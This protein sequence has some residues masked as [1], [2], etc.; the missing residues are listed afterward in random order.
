MQAL[1]DQQQRAEA[2]RRRESRGRAG[3]GRGE[4]RRGEGSGEASSAPWLL[5]GRRLRPEGLGPLSWDIGKVLGL[6]GES[7]L[8]S[9]MSM[10]NPFS[11]GTSEECAGERGDEEFREKMEMWWGRGDNQCFLKALPLE[12]PQI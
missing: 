3:R 5:P 1:R 8:C 9:E 2:G 11:L 6:D 10:K 7:G 4:V 12:C